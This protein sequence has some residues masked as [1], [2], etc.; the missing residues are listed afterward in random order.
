MP[1]RAMLVVAV[2]A[3]VFAGCGGDDSGGN[4]GGGG[5]SAASASKPFALAVGV[6]PV[7]TP[8]FVALEEGLFEKE[9]L[10]VDVQQYANAGEAA[11]ALIAGSADVAGVPDYN[12]LARAPRANLAAMEIF[13]EDPGD[14]VKVVAGKGI[15]GPE[16]MKK[17]GIV[18]GTYSEYA[19]AKLL[20]SANIDPSSVKFVPAGP[21]E[22]PPLLEKGDIDGYVIWPPWT[23]RGEESGGKILYP[24]REYGLG[25]VLTIAAKDEWLKGHPQEAAALRRVMDAATKLTEQD[26]AAAAKA[27]AKAAK[28]PEPLTESAIGEIDFQVRDF[29]DKDRE[30][31]QAIVDYLAA[32]KVIKEKPSLDDLIVRPS[33]SGS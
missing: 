20:E 9:G 3:A 30:S 13:A 24:T 25:T 26:P 1:F 4:G 22:L 19:A 5:D 17:I 28:L 21:P 31:F 29:T 15:S 8:I 7:F 32:R 18:P 23:T 27:A 14:Y 6:D 12:L 2:V 10:Q 11:D 16:E 33:S